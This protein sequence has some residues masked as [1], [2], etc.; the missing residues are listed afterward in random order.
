MKGRT[1]L[2]LSV[3]VLSGLGCLSEPAAPL[4]EDLH[5]S[6]NRVERYAGLEPEAPVLDVLDFDTPVRILEAHRSYVRVRTED[7]QE[8]WV[9]RSSLLDLKLRQRVRLLTSLTAASPAQGLYRSRD[10]LN[11][12]VEPYRWSPTF[13]QLQK[14]E[15]FEVLDR[16]LVDRLPAA[17]VESPAEY[18]PTGLD[19]WYLV[20]IPRIS[21]TGWLIANMAYADLPLEIVR[22]ARGRQISGYHRLG[23]TTDESTGEQ[24]PTWLWVQSSRRD[25]PEDFDSLSVFQWDPHRSRYLIIRQ[26]NGLTGLLPVTVDP[27]RGSGGS[28]ERGVRILIEKEGALFE[29]SYLYAGRRFRRLGDEAVIGIPTHSPSG[30][31]NERYRPGE[32]Y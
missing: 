29:R 2:G 5:Y 26:E 7:E 22:L 23:A 21:Q 32:A 16:T 27:T 9:P 4:E 14:D 3:A 13:F 25:G 30:F 15:E 1:G 31:F 28:A 11:V 10:T 18:P 8:G 20:R 12:H 24:K 6:R 19:H 17:A